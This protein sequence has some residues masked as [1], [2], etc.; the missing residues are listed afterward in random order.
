M[1]LA[2]DAFILAEACP[3]IERLRV[4]IRT[5]PLRSAVSLACLA[6]ATS[7][8]SAKL[9][10]VDA[11]LFPPPPRDAITFW[12]H[13]SCYVDIGG[14]G[15]VTDPVFDKAL[16]SFIRSRKVP[17]P[18]RASYARA[19]VVLISHAHKDHL[20]PPTLATFPDSTLILCPEP[21]AEHLDKLTNPVRVMR[22]GDTYNFSG[23]TITA[24]AAEHPGGRWSLNAGPDGRALGYVI[25]TSLGSIFYSGDTDFFEGFEH[26]A[27]DHGPDVAL[28]NINNKHLSADEA[29]QAAN[30]LTAP[31][32]VPLHFG[33]F[34]YFFLDERKRPRHYERVENAL[35]DRLR[36]LEVGES[37][38]LRDALRPHQP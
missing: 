14:Y 19:R 10:R 7:G 37:L 21:A 24:V 9:A 6:A 11:D 31:M 4:L 30:A 22:P 3:W 33:V 36:L 18:P 27:R 34:G 16:F 5:Q 38:L 29:V 25:D 17:A 1:H 32:V 12:G 26:V 2:G 15:I 35:G 13:A 20:S 8:C 23:G 28:L